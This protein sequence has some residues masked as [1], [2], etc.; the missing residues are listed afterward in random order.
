MSGSEEHTAAATMQMKVRDCI[1]EMLSYI[2]AADYAGHDPY[3]LD[4][5]VELVDLLTHY[6]EAKVTFIFVVSRA[7]AG[8]PFYHAAQEQIRRRNLESRFCLYN[9]PVDFV[10][11]M[12]RCDLVLRPANTDGGALTVREA[13][14]CGVPVIASDVVQRPSG[15]ILFR[16]R[17]VHDLMS[18]TLDVLEKETRRGKAAVPADAHFRRYLDLYLEVLRPHD[19]THATT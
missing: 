5:C 17:D 16:N 19:A 7:A 15:T 11:L 12:K 9:K 13:L 6:S 10:A 2:E 3:G 18:R 4:L 8:N 14:Y 1:R